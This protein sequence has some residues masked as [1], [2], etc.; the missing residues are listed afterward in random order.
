MKSGTRGAQ[1]NDGETKLDDA[2]EGASTPPDLKHVF[3][4]T[5]IRR[6][7]HLAYG[8]QKCRTAVVVSPMLVLETCMLFVKLL[9]DLFR[10]YSK[11]LDV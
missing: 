3:E 4:E 11:S 5:A 7:Y 2:S 1:H 9:I 6:Y 10:Q 8:F